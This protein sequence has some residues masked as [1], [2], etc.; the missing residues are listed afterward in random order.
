MAVIGGVLLLLVFMFGG[1]GVLQGKFKGSGCSGIA[2]G[3]ALFLGIPTHLLV[4]IHLRQPARSQNL[5]P[6]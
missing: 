6:E 4:E 3:A 2:A 1:A 5:P